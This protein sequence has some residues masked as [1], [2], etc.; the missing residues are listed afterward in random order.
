MF[1]AF[2]MV[3]PALAQDDQEPMGGESYE[4]YIRRVNPPST[5][6]GDAFRTGPNTPLNSIAEQGAGYKSTADFQAIVGAVI[7]MVLGLLGV[8]FLVLAIYAGYSWMTAGG[9][10]EIV[11]KAR[12]TIINSVIGIIIVLAAYALS[13]LIVVTFGG[14]VF[15]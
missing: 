4:D 5:G 14:L 6:L 9:N 8:V 10:E 11:E 15:K 3:A 12:K 2:F 13:R 7:T 1:S